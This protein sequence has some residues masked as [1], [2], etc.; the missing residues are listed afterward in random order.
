VGRKVKQFV[1]EVLGTDD[2]FMSDEDISPGD[3]SLEEIDLALKNST[4]ALVMVSARSMREPWLNFEAGAMAVRLTKTSVIPI[5]LDLTFSQL[6]QPLAQFQA[7]RFDDAE[8][9]RRMLG[10]LNAH[11]EG[12]RIKSETLD[13]V[14]EA[15]WPTFQDDVS[16]IIAANATPEDQ[17]SLPGEADK[18]DEILATLRSLSS[19]SSATAVKLGGSGSLGATS[20]KDSSNPS[21]AVI[22]RIL[23]KV[24][25]IKD[26]R[27]YV[28]SRGLVAEVQTDLPDLSPSMKVSL[29]D[30]AQDLGVDI[31][32]LTRNGIDVF[33][34]RGPLGRNGLV[35]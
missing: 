13:I 32:V 8:K 34:Q 10:V 35:G 12:D 22:R 18:I 28:G 30:I 6:V 31:E 7:I 26:F 16:G 15:R 17:E 21:P 24:M 3:K 11:R 27:A 2:V 33:E 5:L 19:A 1:S 20:R 23:S 14:F 25:P 9:F 4:A 29:G